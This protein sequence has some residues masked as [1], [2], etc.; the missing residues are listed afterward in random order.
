MAKYTRSN[1][2]AWPNAGYYLVRF[3]QVLCSVGIMGTLSYF[4]YALLKAHLGIPYE[5]II[6]YVAVCEWSS[7]NPLFNHM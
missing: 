4:I 7:Y 2:D 5:F 1:P 3:L 6:L